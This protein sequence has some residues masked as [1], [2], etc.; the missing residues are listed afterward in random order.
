MTTAHIHNALTGETITRDMTEEETALSKVLTKE[1]K[2]LEADENAKAAKKAAALE[3][4]GLTAD[5][6]TALFG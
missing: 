3:K 5:E 2:K 1:A 4:L 6:A